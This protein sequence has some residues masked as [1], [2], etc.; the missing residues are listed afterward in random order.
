MREGGT[1]REQREAEE[2]GGEQREEEERGGARRSGR[3]GSLACLWSSSSVASSQGKPS[4]IRMTSPRPSLPPFPTQH[5][6]HQAPPTRPVSSLYKR[7]MQRVESHTQRRRTGR[8][9][10]RRQNRSRTLHLRLGPS[11]GAPTGREGVGSLP[12]GV[13]GGREEPPGRCS[14][15][16]LSRDGPLRAVKCEARLR[17]VYLRAPLWRNIWRL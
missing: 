9:Q 5:R 15:L 2:G 6:R 8:K 14:R 10:N 3:G 4:I 17:C 16:P 12:G 7:V 13:T 1:G 11:T